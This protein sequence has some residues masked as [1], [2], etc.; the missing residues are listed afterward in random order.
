MKSGENIFI[1]LNFL[2]NIFAGEAFLS[3]IETKRIW[4]YAR[5]SEKVNEEHME[6]GN[7]E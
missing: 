5:K 3:S 4:Y 1:A 2:Q 7:K 6:P